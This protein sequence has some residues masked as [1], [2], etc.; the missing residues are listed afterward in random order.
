[1]TTVKYFQALQNALRSEMERD[2]NVVLFGEDVGAS[3]GIFGQTKGL[4]G[5]F[6]PNRVRDTPIAENGFVS[7]AVGAAMTG[8]RPIVEVGFEDF[9]TACMDPLVNQ[10]AKLRYMLGG[11]VSVP[12]VLYT[13]GGGGLN[14]GPQ[15]SQSF[16][17]WFAQ[18]PGLKV[19]M[20]ATPSDTFLMTKAAVRDNNPVIVLLS[21]K[22]IGTVGE[23]HADEGDLNSKL[24]TAYVTDKGDDITLLAFGAMVPVA[25]EAR[26]KLA[27]VG[28]SAE[29]ING[30]C[31]NPFDLKTI[32]ASVNKTGRLAIIHEAHQP[33]GLGAEVISGLI[34]KDLA[35]FKSS[36]IRITP[37]FA[38]S[39][40][41]PDLEKEYLPSS[42][43]IFE[44]VQSMLTNQA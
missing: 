30:C 4:Y 38:P 41:A 23:L 29:V 5:Q 9:L 13:F 3:G 25:I 17:S 39:P 40:F 19:V 37:P 11:Q 32:K 1:M 10:A 18:V 16:V 36:P 44:R 6:G 35:I 2:E 28:C 20:P 14:A 34:E 22:L 27:E 43:Q 12:M 31:A 8:L 15:H 33:C 26:T 24:D 7:A 42:G 21:K